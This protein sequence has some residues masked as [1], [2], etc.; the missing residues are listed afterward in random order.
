MADKVLDYSPAELREM[1][2]AE[3]DFHYWQSDA[4]LKEVGGLKHRIKRKLKL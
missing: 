2:E 3:S 1:K 4:L